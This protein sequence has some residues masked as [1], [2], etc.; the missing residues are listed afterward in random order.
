[1]AV[2]VI[3][4][5]GSLKRSLALT[6]G[7][8]TGGTGQELEHKGH[9]RHDIHT[10][11]GHQKGGGGV[12]V[13]RRVLPSLCAYYGWVGS[14]PAAHGAPSMR[15]PWPWTVQRHAKRVLHNPPSPN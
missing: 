2:A 1:M 9:T 11:L 3:T 14:R 8:T 10:S 15:S 7:V 12:H 4:P 5:A 6:T 13:R